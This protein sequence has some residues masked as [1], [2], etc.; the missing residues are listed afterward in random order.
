MKPYKP[1]EHD[2]DDEIEIPGDIADRLSNAMIY[3]AIWGIGGATDEFTR[4]KFNTFFIELIRGDD[5]IT[6][7]EIDV[8]RPDG[9]EYETTKIPNKLGEVNSVFDMYFD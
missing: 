1:S 9:E 7:Y 8:R 5:V 4:H 3:A 6:K 2:E